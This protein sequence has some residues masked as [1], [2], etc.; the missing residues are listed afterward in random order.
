MENSENKRGESCGADPS[1]KNA[2]ESSEES[3]FRERGRKERV[4]HTRISEQLAEDIR[5]VAEDLRVPVSNL[6]RNVLEETF[7]VVESV[8]DN[9]GTWLEDVATEVGRG[10][11]GARRHR[12]ARPRA[13][14]RE[15]E[16]AAGGERDEAAWEKPWEEPSPA[17]PKKDPE[18]G[19]GA[20]S[21][22]AREGETPPE[23]PADSG[24][25][26]SPGGRPDFSQ[27]LG[28]Q[29]LV[30]N[31]PQSCADCERL[32]VRGDRAYLGLTQSGVSGLVLCRACMDARE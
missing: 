17:S 22:P 32:L 6:V 11:P 3:G 16:E 18:D 8:T 31:R 9:L 19:L 13:R 23:R 25:A 30:M 2:G 21:S 15:G 27:V 10:S 14:E 4:L 28:W 20:P 24:G 26:P 12:W 5:R 29:P 7:S 1:G